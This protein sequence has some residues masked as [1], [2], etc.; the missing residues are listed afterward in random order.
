MMQNT[1][2]IGCSDDEHLR[3]SAAAPSGTSTSAAHVDQPMCRLGIAAYWFETSLS[4]SES[5]DQSVAVVGERVARSRSSRLGV[6]R[7]GGGPKLDA[8]RRAGAAA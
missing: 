6:L 4:V 3:P 1:V 5:N 7:S 2:A 8:A